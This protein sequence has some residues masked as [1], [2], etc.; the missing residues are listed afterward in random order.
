MAG[1]DWSRTIVTVNPNTA[2]D[3]VFEVPEFEVG[4][5]VKGRLLSQTPAGKGINVSRALA[6]LGCD[7][8]ATGF[9]GEAQQPDFERHLKSAG[10]GR[11]LSQL[12]AVAGQT[13]QNITL[14]DPVRHTDTHIRD[15][16]FHVSPQDVQRITS[17]VGLLART[18]AMVLFTGSLPPGMEM[19]DLRAMVEQAI[20]S[21]ALVAMDGD[22]DAL[23]SML[24]WARADRAGKRFW[25]LKP[26]RA[27]LAGAV[28]VK[29]ID[30]LEQALA[31]A[32]QL[33][34]HAQV[35]CVT[36]GPQG[37]LIVDEHEAWQ[38]TVQ[39]EPGMVVNTVGCGDCAMA[40]L[41]DAMLNQKPPREAVR[42]AVATGA[43]NAL[44]Q[45]IA[46][47]SVTLVDE[48]EESVRV[49]PLR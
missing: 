43:A 26:N 35:V 28:G 9:V 20:R 25:M 3:C 22:V 5:H 7:S 39:V 31:A 8:V 2:V 10:P 47:F 1:M 44:T 13:R 21:G 23:Q 45:G 15:R 48:L 11:A 38:A 19:H 41:L 17:K 34:H 40:G 29:Q 14:V 12:L 6:R 42:R 16:G 18:D 30:T 37:A 46:Q 49:E 33:L 24:A 4:R 27:E 32:R 36:L